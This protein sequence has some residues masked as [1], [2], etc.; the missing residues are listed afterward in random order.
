MKTVGY[1]IYLED[2]VQ[3][4]ILEEKGK[5][6]KTRRP[7]LTSSSQSSCLNSFST[8]QD[9]KPCWKANV[10]S[11]GMEFKVLLLFSS[12]FLKKNLLFLFF[13]FKEIKVCI[14]YPIKML[15]RWSHIRNRTTVH[16][17][18]CSEAINLIVS[19]YSWL[20]KAVK[21]GEIYTKVHGREKKLKGW[22]F[23]CFAIYKL[24]RG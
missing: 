8:Y 14:L 15:S 5:N 16:E 9:R 2:G 24:G 18:K 22:F 23:I 3:D 6:K 10:V 19:L 11:W 13:F 7:L 12:L 20:F 17:I 1:M 4:L 21:L